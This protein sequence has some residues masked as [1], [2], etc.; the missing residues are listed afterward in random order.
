VEKYKNEL[1]QLNG[2]QEAYRLDIEGAKDKTVEFQTALNRS[3]AEIKNLSSQLATAQSKLITFG[4][5]AQQVGKKWEAAGKKVNEIGNGLTLGVSTPLLAVGGA[6][7]KVGNDFESQM[8]RIKAISGATGTEFEKLEKQAI[9]LGAQT[10]FSATE[11]AEAMENL[12]SAGFGTNEIMEA[13]PGMLDLAASSGEDLASSADIAASTLRGFGLEA[14]QAGH[15]A[16]VLAKN[17]ADTNAAISDT[18]TAMKYIAPVAH[19]AGWSLEEVTTAIGKLA[20]AGI[21]GDQ[22]G[23]TLRGGLARLMQPTKAMKK[24]TKQ[25]STEFYDAQGKMKPLSTIIDDL[26]KGT[27]KMTDQQRDNALATIFGTE[28]LSGWKVLLGSSKPEL[29]KLTNGL[30]NCDGAAKDMANTMLDNTAGSIEAMKG[31]LETAGITLQKVMAP[32]VKMIADDV[33]NLANSFSKLPSPIQ[34]NIVKLGALAIA[35][36]PVVKGIGGVISGAGKAAKTVGKL[37]EK[38][39]KKGVA[40]AAE[41]AA[42]AA[43]GASSAAKTATAVT[44]EATGSTSGLNLALSGVAKSAGL[45]A[46]G[47]GAFAGGVAA[48]GIAAYALEKHLTQADLAKRFGEITLSAEECS[49]A[50]KD[51][52]DTK[53]SAKLSLVTDAKKKLDETKKQ[54]Q[55]TGKEIEKYHYMATAGIKLTGNESQSYK[56]A[57]G[58][59]ISDCQEYLRQKQVTGELA[60]SASFIPTSKSYSSLNSALDGLYSTYNAKLSQLSKQMNNLTTAALKDGVIDA[61]ES[62][63]IEA[64]KSKMQTVVDT[65]SYEKYDAHLKALEITTTDTRLSLQSAGQLAA[66][67]SKENAVSAGQI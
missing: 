27:A 4:T 31:S 21:K 49:T 54:V 60:I 6:A 10:S 39:G 67:V 14:G 55:D 17:V 48:L 12:A 43:G 56:S 62:K 2:K 64:L 3:Q 23:T 16:D 20:D 53:W 25:C 59:Y 19:S 15:V 37:S 28:S 57:I 8:S 45:S 13:M 36:G 33:T 5:A 61:D 50:A 9:D 42:K 30:K 40:A 65:V 32:S 7:L 35:T 52:V 66:E 47:V 18:G 38:L 41:E 26:Q 44:G 29:D 46:A 1:L 51:F 58:K 11:S 24:A 34:A 22:A 63:A